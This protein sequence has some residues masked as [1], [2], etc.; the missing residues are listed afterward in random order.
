MLQNANYLPKMI[1]K[2]T[3]VEAD[4]NFCRMGM[5]YCLHKGGFKGSYV[6]LTATLLGLYT[7]TSVKEGLIN[8]SHRAVNNSLDVLSAFNRL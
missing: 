4:T 3:K 6:G 7:S 5:F 1:Y 2:E 8:S